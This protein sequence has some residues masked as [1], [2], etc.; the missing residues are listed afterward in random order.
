MSAVCLFLIR[1]VFEKL[2]YCRVGVLDP[3]HCG[4]DLFLGHEIRIDQQN[5]GFAL[6]HKRLVFGI[7]EKAQLSGFSVLDLCE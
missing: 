7:C 5:V 1:N 4:A 2:R 3:Y 6:I